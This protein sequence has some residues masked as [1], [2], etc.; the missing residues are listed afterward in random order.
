M[1][2]FFTREYENAIKQGSLEYQ[3][4]LLTLELRNIRER[5]RT[6]RRA[7]QRA[8]DK[9]V[10]RTIIESVTSIEYEQNKKFIQTLELVR[11]QTKARIQANKK[12][13]APPK[14]QSFKALHVGQ[15]LDQVKTAE[16]KKPYKER[17]LSARISH[18]SSM[19]VEEI[20][21]R[22][23]YTGGYMLLPY[24]NMLA[25][26]QEYDWVFDILGMRLSDRYKN[27]ILSN[28]EDYASNDAYAFFESVDEYITDDVEVDEYNGHTREEFLKALEEIKYRIKGAM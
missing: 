20:I 7:V 12:G 3:Q 24:E 17:N 21:R 9:G 25:L 16:L 18:Q 10:A 1:R 26:E 4:K 15:K 6:I 8:E 5:Q 22:M 14:I 13:I 28:Y 23:I 19:A 2:S 27:D 11:A